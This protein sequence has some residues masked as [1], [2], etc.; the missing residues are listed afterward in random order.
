MILHNLYEVGLGDLGSQEFL[1]TIDKSRKTPMSPGMA[2]DRRKIADALS[3]IPGD[4]AMIEFLSSGWVT[5]KPKAD[6]TPAFPRDRTET[7]PSE[8]AEKGL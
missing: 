8:A 6:Q 1:A 7:S 5:G 2:L 3:E 4:G